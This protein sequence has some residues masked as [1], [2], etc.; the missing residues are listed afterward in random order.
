MEELQLEVTGSYFEGYFGGPS[1]TL[2]VHVKLLWRSNV[3][4]EGPRE[5]TLEVVSGH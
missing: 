5:V 3:H 1:S 4:I 2:K